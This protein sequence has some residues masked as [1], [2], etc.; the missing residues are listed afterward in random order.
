MAVYVIQNEAQEVGMKIYTVA[1][2]CE[3]F[4]LHRQTITKA[5]AG[6]ELQAMKIGGE[7]RISQADLD[8]WY[9]SSGGGR[10]SEDYIDG[11]LITGRDE[12]GLRQFI[13][14]PKYGLIPL[15]GGSIIEYLSADGWEAV[16]YE[17]TFK[18]GHFADLYS[19]KTHYIIACIPDGTVV[20]KVRN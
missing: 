6:G 11:K 18:E 3:I 7:Y 15:H 8:N 4:Q 5:I 13:D 12:G 2:V 20:R 14:S 1:E 17:W 19:L 9:R 10:L 16:R